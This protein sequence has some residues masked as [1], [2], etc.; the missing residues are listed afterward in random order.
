MATGTK[1]EHNRYQQEVHERD[2]LDFV[3][4]IPRDIDER[5]KRIV[6][7]AGL[8]EGDRVLDVGTGTGVLIPHF[9]RAGVQHIVGCDLT[10]AMLEHAQRQYPDV[11]YFCGDVLEL[12][13]EHCEFSAIFLN[14]IFGNL[15]DQGATLAF[16]AGRL[17][18]AGSIFISHPMG[19]G[20]V[21][22][23][24][25]ADPMRTPNRLPDAERLRELV[26][27]LPLSVATLVEESDLYLAHLTHTP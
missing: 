15:V 11:A 14:A 26:A 24:R 4:R 10:A 27:N 23:L 5:T 25:Q 3:S 19:A 6:D 18:S 12:P 1:G 9:Q 22:Q 16:L 21:D 7:A 13:P 20:F 17:R 8:A 2:V